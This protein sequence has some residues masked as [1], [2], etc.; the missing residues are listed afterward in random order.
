MNNP[1]SSPKNDWATR[2]FPGLFSYTNPDSLVNRLREKRMGHLLKLLKTPLGRGGKTRILDIGG[3]TGFWKNLGG[4][5]PESHDVVL[6]NLEQEPVDESLPNFS[7]VSGNA[8]QLP[9]GDQSFD[10]VFSNS[11]IEHVGSRE[12]QRKM[13]AEIRRVGRR[14]IIQTPG[15]W[16]PLEPH[17]RLPLFQFLP[18]SVRAFLIF[19]GHIHYFPKAPTYRECL[20]VSDSTILLT[21]ADM[22]RLFPEARIMTERLLGLPKSYIALYGWDHTS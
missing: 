6:L 15:F 19:H 22:C 21:R 1:S 14:Y 11:V 5:P 20:A 18:R 7:S 9:F 3:T 4:L 12:N 16:F 10:I 13:A 2:L 8:L 17:A